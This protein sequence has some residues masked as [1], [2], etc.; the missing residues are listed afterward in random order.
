M[1][2]KVQ[3]CRDALL[4]ECSC[5]ERGVLLGTLTVDAVDA[6]PMLARLL[7]CSTGELVG[8][9]TFDGRCAWTKAPEPRESWTL[10]LCSYEKKINAI[11]A[12]RATVPGMGLK[13]A[14]E[15]VDLVDAGPQ[16]VATFGSAEKA[17]H[18]ATALRMAGCGVKVTRHAQ[19]A[20]SEPTTDR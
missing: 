12:L 13:D 14:K 9:P 6:G 16:V 15:I 20:E 18:D 19:E 8:T 4:L 17:E 5:F 7:G 3:T 11:K 2:T 1:I 10:L